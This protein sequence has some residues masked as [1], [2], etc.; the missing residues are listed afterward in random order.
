M[1]VCV[2]GGVCVCM[3]VR[4]F[5]CPEQ[6]CNREIVVYMIAF[7]VRNGIRLVSVLFNR[8]TTIVKRLYNSF[9]FL[10]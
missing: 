5:Y 9:L 10:N 6:H 2:G 1:C 3:C 8:C 7:V 4:V